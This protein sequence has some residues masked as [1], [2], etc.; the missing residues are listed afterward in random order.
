MLSD[1]VFCS[2]TKNDIYRIL[3]EKAH[4]NAYTSYLRGIR[5]KTEK[6]FFMKYL[7]HFSSPGISEKIGLRLMSV[8]VI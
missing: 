7:H 2:F 4:N 6:D 5:C 1:L 3:Y 8:F